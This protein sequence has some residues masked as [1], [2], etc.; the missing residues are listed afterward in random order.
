MNREPRQLLGYGLAFSVALAVVVSFVALGA[1]IV[2]S[3]AI[4]KQTQAQVAEC[5]RGNATKRELGGTLDELS[6]EAGER[7]D[8]RRA[9]E[10]LARADHVRSQIVDCRRAARR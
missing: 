6:S 9:D 3:N 4:E 1:S 7:E 10:Y 2:L 8:I 5:R